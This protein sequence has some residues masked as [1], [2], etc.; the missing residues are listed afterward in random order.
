[1]RAG[2]DQS[3][4]LDARLPTTLQAPSRATDRH[5]D[6]S[7]PLL[8]V[9]GGEQLIARNGYKVP[10][11]YPR[12]PALAPGPRFCPRGY[13]ARAAH[14]GSGRHPR[15]K[16]RSDLVTCVSGPS[17]DTHE[18]NERRGERQGGGQP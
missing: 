1:M 15:W 18:L 4:Y 16:G 14:W 13:A 6:A 2:S 5:G 12:A 11:P 7:A 17:V 3:G 10:S 8:V 9:R